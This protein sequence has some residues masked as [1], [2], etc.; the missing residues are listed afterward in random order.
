MNLFSPE[1]DAKTL[2]DAM[3][4]LGTDELAI[5]K[6]VANRTN[7]QR[8]K[9]L[10]A[11]K[12]CYGRDLIEDL[13]DELSGN[14]EDA[15]IAL[16]N[17]PV[18]YDAK[19]LRKAMKG[20]GT[21]ESTLIEIIAT[22]PSQHLQEVKKAFTKLFERNLEDDIKSETSGDLQRLLIALLQGNR[23][24][25]TN[26]DQAKCKQ[27]ADDLYNSGEGKWGTDESLF[28]LIFTQRSP[29]ELALIEKF[30]YNQYGK[31][32]HHIIES[33]FSGDVKELF[34][35]IVDSMINP[36][37]YFATRVNKAVKGW[38]TDDNL[39]IRILVTRDEIDMPL[40]KKEYFNLYKRQ[41]LEDVRDD[42][43]GDYKVLLIE[44]AGH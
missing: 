42:T 39:L 30:Y 12:S 27:D 22:R 24:I 38:G 29:N 13:K 4:G 9:I 32:F 18:D 1:V 26:P 19:Q 2:R 21:D 15:I 43:S 31:Y 28:T 6:L 16:F 5:T 10:E 36:T 25:N 11:Y 7:E 44:L 20:A 40:I 3:K 33:E 34:L 14:Y 37:R 23:S 41:M 35:T 8:Q 17:T